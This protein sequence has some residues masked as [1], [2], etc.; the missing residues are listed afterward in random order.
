MS[1]M[2]TLVFQ[3]SAPLLVSLCR[4]RPPSETGISA[5][6]AEKQQLPVPEK[7]FADK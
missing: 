7:R 4:Q 1:K 5:I 3:N 6:I 2:C